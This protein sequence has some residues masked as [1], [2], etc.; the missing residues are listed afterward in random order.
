MRIGIS[1]TGQKYLSFGIPGT[2]LYFIKHLEE[3]STSTAPQHTGVYPQATHNS[4]TNNQ[5]VLDKINS[6]KH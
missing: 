1:P 4:Q 6:M 3:S 2:G 5:E